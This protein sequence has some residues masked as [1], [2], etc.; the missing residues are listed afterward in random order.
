MNH[1]RIMLRRITLH[2]IMG[3][4]MKQILVKFDERIFHSL[5]GEMR[6]RNWVEGWVDHKSL[7]ATTMR[8]IITKVEEG[9]TEVKIGVKDEEL[10]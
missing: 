9:K 4:K 6:L 7:S 5:Q 3:K 2:R 1:R 10:L 8:D